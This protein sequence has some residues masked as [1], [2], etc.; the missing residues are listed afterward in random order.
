MQVNQIQKT[1]GL[2]SVKSRQNSNP[3]IN[4]KGN[5]NSL[6]KEANKIIERHVESSARIPNMAGFDCYEDILCCNIIVMQKK[7]A[8]IFKIN[9]KT[10]EAKSFVLEEIKR[11]PRPNFI[12]RSIAFISGSG[13]TTEQLRFMYV[14]QRMGK[15][16]IE[17]CKKLKEQG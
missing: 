5:A 14:T 17:H 15:E 9:F 3:N 12:L 2:P 6:L 4:F 10:D 8:D 13:L 11:S 16:F 1:N 7:I